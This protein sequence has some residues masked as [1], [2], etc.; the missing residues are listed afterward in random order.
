M[1]ISNNGEI[2]L[3]R[4]EDILEVNCLYI[5]RSKLKGREVVKRE[6]RESSVTPLVQRQDRASE[7]LEKIIVIVATSSTPQ[8]IPQHRTNASRCRTN[9]RAKAI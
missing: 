8:T 4:N 1:E 6:P 3:S 5:F 2:K 7:T 9:T